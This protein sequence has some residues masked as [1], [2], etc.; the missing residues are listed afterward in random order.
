MRC[1]DPTRRN[2]QLPCEAQPSPHRSYF[3]LD[4]FS[5]SAFHISHCVMFEWPHRCCRPSR[6]RLAPPQLAS[7]LTVM[8]SSLSLISF[9]TAFNVSAS[10]LLFFARGLSILTSC[11]NNLQTHSTW[12]NKLWCGFIISCQQCRHDKTSTRL[13][14]V[15]HHFLT[16]S[17]TFIACHIP[18]LVVANCQSYCNFLLRSRMSSMPHVLNLSGHFR[19]LSHFSFLCHMSAPTLSSTS[20]LSSSHTSHPITSN[21]SIVPDRVVRSAAVSC[22][23]FA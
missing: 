13:D 3:D 21:P 18:F 1:S 15:N 5:M 2:R 12:G 7:S 20:S 8:A 9:F 10:C 11:T 4:C 17:A 22:R 14:G 19:H 16:Q 23:A 6:Y